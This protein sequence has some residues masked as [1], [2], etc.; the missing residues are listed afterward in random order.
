MIPENVTK[1]GRSAFNSCGFKNIVLPEGLRQIEG[2]T[3][4]GC[5]ELQDITI[6]NSV[7]EIGDE[8]FYGC[9]KLKT[10]Y[11]TADSYAQS[12]AKENEYSFKTIDYRR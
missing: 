5:F 12:Y 11:G 10:I 2:M 1:I 9:N 6:P 7:T 8:A 4:C 3:F